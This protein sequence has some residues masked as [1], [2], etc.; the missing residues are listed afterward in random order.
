MHTCRISVRSL[1]TLLSVTAA[2]LSA[3]GGCG[4]P[5]GELATLD[6]VQAETPSP[7]LVASTSG[8]AIDL[9]CARGRFC[10]QNT[11]AIECI[12]ESECGAGESCD[13]TR[14]R[15]VV[16]AAS[17][18]LAGIDGPAPA[19]SEAL[20]NLAPSS[21]VETIFFIEEGA[22]SV[23]FVVEL[24][25]ELPAQGASYRVVRSDDQTTGERVLRS[26][27]GTS[28]LVIPLDAGLASP[29]SAAPSLVRVDVETPFGSWLVAVSYTH[30]RAHE[31]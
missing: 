29:D 31:T 15:C 14:G 30:L 1:Q 26:S 22:Q 19:T 6:G 12:E 23:N 17:G 27:G 10:F 21:E 24:D 9:D 18:L 4:E 2:L 7:Y 20:P 16:P 11:C 13:I 3:C 5:E 25:G 28:S 8:C